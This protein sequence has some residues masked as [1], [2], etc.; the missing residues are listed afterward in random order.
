MS[1]ASESAPPQAR[2]DKYSVAVRMNFLKS[3]AINGE[4]ARAVHKS[5]E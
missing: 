2:P 3:P 4:Y 1:R 5:A